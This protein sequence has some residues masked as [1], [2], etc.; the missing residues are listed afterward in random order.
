VLSTRLLPRWMGWLVI[1]YGLAGL[2]LLGA[3]SDVPPFLYYLLPMVMGI[4][5]LVRRDQVPPAQDEPSRRNIEATPDHPMS[6]R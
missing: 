4:L 6:L 2:G 5:L 1:V 3:T